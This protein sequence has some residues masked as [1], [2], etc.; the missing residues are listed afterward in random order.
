[1]AETKFTPGPW[2]TTSKKP[3][4]ICADE[5]VIIGQA[6]MPP[7]RMHKAAWEAAREVSHANAALI[8]AAPD[9]YDAL[10][11]ILEYEGGAESALDDEYVMER[12]EL[13]LDK[14]RGEQ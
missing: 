5:G 3:W 12:A 1:M 2:F 11:E 8:A 7:R 14:A 10:V 4:R 6:G 13:A 9:L